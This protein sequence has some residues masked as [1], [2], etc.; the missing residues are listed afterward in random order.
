MFFLSLL[1][2]SP[3][4]RDSQLSSVLVQLAVYVCEV[5]VLGIR[6]CRTAR[7]LLACLMRV[8]VSWE[9]WMILHGESVDIDV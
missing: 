1:Y 6:G 8:D 9:S 3:F 4:R 5:L 2:L 7:A